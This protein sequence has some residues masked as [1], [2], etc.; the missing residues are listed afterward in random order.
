MQVGQTVYF[1]SSDGREP[2]REGK[3]T[4]IGKKYFKVDVAYRT[5]FFIKNCYEDKTRGSRGYL[6]KQELDDTQEKANLLN[7]CEQTKWRSLNL[8]ILRQVVK[9]LKGE[10]EC[11]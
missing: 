5:R 4:E 1:S 9:T 10:V 6:S 7:I 11:F 3:I 8:K 2:I